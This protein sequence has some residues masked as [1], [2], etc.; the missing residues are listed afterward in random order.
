MLACHPSLV[1]SRTT[2][3]SP[4][5]GKDDEAAERIER[6]LQ[7]C[8][9]DADVLLKARRSTTEPTAWV[10]SSQRILERWTSNLLGTEVDPAVSSTVSRGVTDALSFISKSIESS[11]RAK[12]EDR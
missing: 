7:D 2:S 8:T 11:V 1:R 4:A 10:A 6:A 3:T 9:L 5:R 12:G